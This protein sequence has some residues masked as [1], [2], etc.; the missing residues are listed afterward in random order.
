MI[1]MAAEQNPNKGPLPSPAKYIDDT[2]LNEA[3]RELKE[4]K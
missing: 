4:G 1:Q 2:Y 3:L